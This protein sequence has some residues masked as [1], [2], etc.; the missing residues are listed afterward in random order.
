MYVCVA[1]YSVMCIWY[2]SYV[3]LTEEKVMC[4]YVCGKNTCL[5]IGHFQQE[6]YRILWTQHAKQLLSEQETLYVHTLFKPT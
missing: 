2:G 5:Y 3:A 6:R 4:L 1:L